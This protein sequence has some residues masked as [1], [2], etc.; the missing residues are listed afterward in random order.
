MYKASISEGLFS[1]FHQ[2]ARSFCFW[3]GKLTLVRF[4]STTALTKSQICSPQNLQTSFLSWQCFIVSRCDIVFGFCIFVVLEG[5]STSYWLIKISRVCLIVCCSCC[6]LPIYLSWW[7]GAF[8]SIFFTEFSVSPG[9]QISMF[10]LLRQKWMPFLTVYT[11]WVTN[12]YFFTFHFSWQAY[13]YV[14]NC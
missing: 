3:Y 13:V 14:Y 7:L 11:V 5:S 2:R 6:P 4:Q 12:V 1:S 8:I 9:Q 10:Y